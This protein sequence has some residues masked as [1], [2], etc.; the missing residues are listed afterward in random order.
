MWAQYVGDVFVGKE[1]FDAG[2]DGAV[3]EQG[4]RDEGCGAGG[5]TA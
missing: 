5:E 4:L 2:L 3:D 1:Y